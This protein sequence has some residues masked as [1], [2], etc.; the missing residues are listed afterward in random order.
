M[1]QLNFI[2]ELINGSISILTFFLLLFLTIYLKYDLHR[3]NFTWKTFFLSSTAVSLV[4]AMFFDKIGTLMTRTVIWAWRVKGGTIVL[5]G[6][7][8]LFLVTG[9]FF[10]AL[11]SIMLIR[12]L[13]RPRFGNWPWL[14]SALFVIGYVIVEIFFHL[15][16]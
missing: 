11:G 8:D 2:L 5:N 7:E 4:V 6:I 10:T 15:M 13:S 12:V 16:R 3:A 9:A 14:I 1:N